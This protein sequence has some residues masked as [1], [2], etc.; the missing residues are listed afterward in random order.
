MG[1]YEAFKF[2]KRVL[3]IV[4]LEHSLS[5]DKNK[6]FLNSLSVNKGI[7][8]ILTFSKFKRNIKADDKSE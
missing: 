8:I 6:T 1:D 2:R 3:Q 5:C 7:K 4:V